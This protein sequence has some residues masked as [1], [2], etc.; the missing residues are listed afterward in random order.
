MSPTLTPILAFLGPSASGKSTVVREL[1]RRGVVTVTPSWTTRPRRGDEDDETVEHRFVTDVE[2]DELEQGSYFLEVVTLFGLPFRYG[3]PAVAPPPGGPVPAIMVRAP[4]MGLVTRHFPN[5]LAY[6]IE[7][8]PE[9]ACRRLLAREV[10]AA[11]IEGRMR[12][13]DQERL[14]GRNLAARVFANETSVDDLV[15]LVQHAIEH[16]FANDA[17]RGESE[18]HDVV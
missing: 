9:K 1:A 4:L 12:D 8:T 16:D 13:F 5:H 17:G 3:L 18:C 6:Q 7:S 10:D 14:L 11:A 2:F 15:T